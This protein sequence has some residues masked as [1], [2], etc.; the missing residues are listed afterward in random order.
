MHHFKIRHKPVVNHKSVVFIGQSLF[1]IIRHGNKHRLKYIFIISVA[2]MGAGS[3][4][5]TAHFHILRN[6][7]LWIV[8]GIAY[9]IHGAAAIPFMHHFVEPM[10]KTLSKVEKEEKEGS[11]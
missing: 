9:F 10:W 7:P 8:D 3:T 6:V 2:A 5:A 1:I 4:M 11:K